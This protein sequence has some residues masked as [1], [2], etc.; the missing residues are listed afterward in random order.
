MQIDEQTF[1]KMPTKL[2]ALFAKAPN[3]SK[4]EV[5]GAFAAYGEAKPK[6]ARSGR[7]GGNAIYG[8]GCSP[9][10]VGHWP[11]DNGGSAARFFYSA[12]ASKSDRDEG[13]DSLPPAVAGIGAMRDGG[14]ESQPRKNTHPT[15][16]P[17]ALMQWLCRLITPPGGTVLDPFMG[18]GSTGKAAVYEGFEFIG[19]EREDEYIKIAEA[20]ITYACTAPLPVAPAVA[21]Q[22]AMT[23]PAN[24]NLPRDLFGE[25]A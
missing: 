14:R 8:G 3:H 23:V 6:A 18:S 17:T 16:K 20:R 24:D 25:V 10:H 11:T 22:P 7:K 12:K 4:D 2:Q 19:C 1:A 5:V 15:V 21:A 13:L 9:D